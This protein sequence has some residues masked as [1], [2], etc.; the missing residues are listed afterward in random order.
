MQIPLPKI[1]RKFRGQHLQGILLKREIVLLFYHAQ[2][3]SILL[4][5]FKYLC[6]II[7]P[8]SIVDFEAKTHRTIVVFPLFHFFSAV[9]GIKPYKTDFSLSSKSTISWPRRHHHSHPYLSILHP[10]PYLSLNYWGGFKRFGWVRGRGLYTTDQ[11]VRLT[12][13]LQFEKRNSLLLLYYIDFICWIFFEHRLIKI[14]SH[15]LNITTKKKETV[16]W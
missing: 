12:R 3:F 7:I 10:T 9:L 5:C 15:I 4:N 2:Y 8:L 14:D 16:L 11:C 6:A 13:V 1:I